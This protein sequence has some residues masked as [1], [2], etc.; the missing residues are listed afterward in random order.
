MH[1]ANEGGRAAVSIIEK[2]S[3]IANPAYGIPVR[4]STISISPLALVT[5]SCASLVSIVGS[6]ALEL[7]AMLLSTSYITLLLVVTRYGVNA[8]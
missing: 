4:A 5:C 6:S 1:S 7:T 8:C 3:Q 2:S